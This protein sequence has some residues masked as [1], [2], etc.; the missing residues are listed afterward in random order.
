M[1]NET[2]KEFTLN[3]QEILFLRKVC[4]ELISRKLPNT[5]TITLQELI[6]H[7]NLLYSTNREL[8]TEC[9]LNEISTGLSFSQ[10]RMLLGLCLRFKKYTKKPE[11]KL[12]AKQISAKINNYT[13]QSDI[14]NF[15]HNKRKSTGIYYN[16]LN[17]KISTSL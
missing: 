13:P 8:F 4:Y 10:I 2:N 7:F 6:K 14:P 17:S 9:S 11:E 15:L 1:N 3:Q 12:M 5:Q 16:W